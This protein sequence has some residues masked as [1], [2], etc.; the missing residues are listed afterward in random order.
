MF[1]IGTILKTK[2]SLSIFASI[3]GPVSYSIS[4]CIIHDANVS[5]GCTLPVSAIPRLRALFLL[6]LETAY[7]RSNSGSAVLKSEI[8]I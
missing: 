1:S 3:D 5:P 6:I 7:G 4:P 2:F 8:V